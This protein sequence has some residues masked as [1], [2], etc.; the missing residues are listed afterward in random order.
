MTGSET[1]RVDP[2]ALTSAGAAFRH[3]GA[4][5]ANL[6]ADRPLGDAADAVPQLATASACHKAQSAVAADTTA[7]AEAAK[8]Y[9]RNLDSAASLYQTQDEAAGAS[10]DKI[11]FRGR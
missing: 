4:E 6:G 1:L 9:G 11:E 10:I 7:I 3:A 8:A 5:L 2:A